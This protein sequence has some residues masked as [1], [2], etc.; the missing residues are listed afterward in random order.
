M[1]YFTWAN[2]ITIA[3]G[4]EKPLYDGEYD[5]IVTFIYI[6]TKTGRETERRF[7]LQEAITLAEYRRNDKRYKN[8]EFHITNA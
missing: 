4:L 7:S 8:F 6:N 1:S 5:K 2:R 3:K